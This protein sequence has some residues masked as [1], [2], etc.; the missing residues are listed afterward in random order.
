MNAQRPI[1]LRPDR[2][3]AAREWRRAFVDD[4]TVNVLARMRKTSADEVRLELRSPVS[5]A[6]VGDFPGG[7]VTQLM[8]LAQDTALAEILDLA[9]KV[10][11]KGVQQLRLS[12]PTN[13]SQAVFIEEGFPIPAASGILDSVLVD[14]VK[15]LAM[16]VPLTNEL[17]NYSAPT[18]SVVISRLLKI[19][20]GNGGAKVL[21]SADPA[22]AAA[23]AGILNGIAP[24]A[25]GASP[26][27][28]IKALLA[29]ISA[30]NISTRSV[31]FVVAPDLA[32][33]LET[34]AWPLFKRKV[35]EANMLAPGTII[36][37]AADGFAVG[38][39]GVPV[40]DVGKS[41]TLHMA[42]P[43]AQLVGADGTVAAPMVSMFATDSFA[44]RAVCR[45]TWA[46]APGSVAWIQN[47]QW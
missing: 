8:I 27:A 17:E 20:V 12:S 34:Q 44:L 28:D 10:D 15:K 38:G 33:S 1:P 5:P 13:F 29:A 9:V 37:I 21:L 36:A 35:I 16:I 45:L 23:P 25:A 30:A 32:A 46:V 2:D 11:L 47:A 39:E 19:S 14:M 26:S 31:F 42:D 3:A 6:R 22:T 4:A 40:V 43:A 7:S 41:A 18:A 24:I